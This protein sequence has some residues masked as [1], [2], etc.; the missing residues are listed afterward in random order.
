MQLVST[1]LPLLLASTF[2]SA[3]P[4]SGMTRSASTILSDFD[5]INSDIDSIS[6][7]VATFNKIA[8]AWNG[9]ILGLAALCIIL[10]KLEFDLTTTAY[11]IASSGTFNSTESKSILSSVTTTTPNIVTLLS[12]L[13][14]QVS[15]CDE[16]VAQMTDKFD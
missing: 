14:A 1:L 3:I 13:D 4:V 10:Q 5:S 9:N 2:T 11:A 15:L 12:D 8:V 6:S 7:D 16:V